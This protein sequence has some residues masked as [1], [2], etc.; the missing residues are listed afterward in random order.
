M[1]FFM[2][3]RALVSC[4]VTMETADGTRRFRNARLFTRPSP[5]GTGNSWL[6]RTSS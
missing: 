4:V 2:A 6:G 5:D 1:T 3:N